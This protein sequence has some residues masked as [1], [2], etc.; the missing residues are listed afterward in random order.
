MI[1]L[2]FSVNLN[3]LCKRKSIEIKVS[4]FDID[5]ELKRNEQIIVVFPCSPVGSYMAAGFLPTNTNKV[6]Y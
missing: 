6:K 4:R 1:L 2:N 5:Y 3:L